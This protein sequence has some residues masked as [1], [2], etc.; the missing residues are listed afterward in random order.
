MAE[1]ELVAKA[2]GEMPEYTSYIDWARKNLVGT[3]YN[4]GTSGMP[5]LTP[6][7]FGLDISSLPVTVENY[8][9][10]SEFESRIAALYGARPA[11]VVS[12]NGSSHANLLAAMALIRPGDAVIIESP[13]YEPIVTLFEYFG[14][15]ILRLPRRAEN[16]WLPDVQELEKMADSRSKLLVMTNPHNPSGALFGEDV[17]AQLSQVMS[18]SGGY[19][20]FDEIYLDFFGKSAPRPAGSFLENAISTSSL[21]KVYGLGTIRAGWAMAAPKVAAEIRRAI[22]YSV[23][24]SSFPSFLVANLVL[25]NFERFRAHSKARHDENRAVFM[26]WLAAET[27]L[28]CHLPDAG[29]IVFPKIVQ[30][31]A[32]CSGAEEA[33]RESG[34]N[35]GASGD[36]ES[37]GAPSM[38][39]FKALK[40]RYETAIVPGVFFDGM[41]EH[42]RL[43]FAPPRARL[44]RALANLSAGLD[45]VTTS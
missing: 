31:F 38:K 13:A 14:A 37:G 35:D 10:F 45:I 39:L 16:G 26:S 41:G 21:T 2:S 19:V 44:E 1:G 6:D 18:R 34:E 12:A 42:F 36:F 28:E 8:S 11:Q 25:D 43:C 29:V 32:D 23:G 4:L 5:P 24:N 15:E 27:R 40:E 30:G 3:K 7:E 9:V 20:L 17:A 22:D 33:S